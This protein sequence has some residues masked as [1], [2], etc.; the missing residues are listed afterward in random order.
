[1][2][3]GPTRIHALCCS[4]DGD[5]GTWSLGWGA[6]LIFHLLHLRFIC[7]VGGGRGSWAE[8]LGSQ[9]HLLPGGASAVS[10]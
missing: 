1:M 4:W 8:L 10:S 9:G 5:H 7:S 2:E 3:E 6:K